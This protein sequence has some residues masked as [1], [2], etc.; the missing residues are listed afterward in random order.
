MVLPESS[1]TEMRGTQDSIRK[2]DVGWVSTPH[3]DHEDVEATNIISSRSGRLSETKYERFEGEELAI[4]PLQVPSD[5]SV[6]VQICQEPYHNPVEGEGE[7][8]APEIITSVVGLQQSRSLV[9]KASRAIERYRF[10][11]RNHCPV[12]LLSNPCRQKVA[13]T[14]R[15]QERDVRLKLQAH[16][17]KRNVMEGELA[18]DPRENGPPGEK[19]NDRHGLPNHVPALLPDS[20]LLAES[21]DP[22]SKGNP[23]SKEPQSTSPRILSLIA[24]P[25][26][27]LKQ[28][29]KTVR[30][31][32]SKRV[33]LPPCSTTRGKTLRE[34]WLSG[35]QSGSR[36]RNSIVPR[37]KMV[38][39]FVRKAGL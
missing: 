19:I 24:V 16:S 38:K 34:S 4:F 39:R 11:P 17:K 10:L 36:D 37:R 12:D 33:L 22:V 35:R 20:I 26:K 1:K 2:K 27:D 3:L 28:D 14:R 8:E 25:P 32:E 9:S 23:P 13:A 31:L 21:A 15:R 18:N 5:E 7:A 30:V 29:F 6:G